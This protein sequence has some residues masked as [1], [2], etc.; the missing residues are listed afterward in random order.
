MSALMDRYENLR[1]AFPSSV[2]AAATL[3]CNPQ[4]VTDDHRDQGNAA[5]VPCAITALGDF[6]P[7]KGGFLVLFDLKLIVRFPPGSTIMFPSGCLRHGTLDIQPG[8]IRYALI[9]YFAGGL[10]R[11]VG[12]GFKLQKA[13]TEADVSREADL[14]ES[15]WADVLGRFSTSGSLAYDRILVT[16]PKLG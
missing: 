10:A 5:G 16:K 13:F 14:A 15:R 12:Y 1:R 9:Q 3:N 7:N 2:W 6:D 4:S 11:H 8:E